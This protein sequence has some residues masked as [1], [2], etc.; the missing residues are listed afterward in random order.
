MREG[1]GGEVVVPREE[2]GILFLFFP[3]VI[4]R[5]ETPEEEEPKAT[6]NYVPALVLLILSS[7]KEAALDK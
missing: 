5:E 4:L 7:A 2:R 3:R 1:E 6:K